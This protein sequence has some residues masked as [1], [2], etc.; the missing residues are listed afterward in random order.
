MTGLV[1]SVGDGRGDEVSAI[2]DD[3][4]GLCQAGTRI[5]FLY[6][7]VDAEEGDEEAGD[8]VDGD[9]ELIEGATTRGEEDVV[10]HGE[11]DEAGVHG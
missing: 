9:E 10:D 6:G 1:F 8:E 2:E 7:G 11:G 5:G 4:A 3:H